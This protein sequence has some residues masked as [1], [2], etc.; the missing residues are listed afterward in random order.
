MNKKE[1]YE[2]VVAEVEA[3]TNLIGV[4]DIEPSY[5]GMVEADGITLRV[6]AEDGVSLKTPTSVFAD[7]D[8]RDGIMG[9]ALDDERF[10]FIL[11][12]KI[13]KA[14]ESK[15]ESNS[16]IEQSDVEALATAGMVLTLWE[17]VGNA[18]N[19]V[20][21]V[22]SLVKQF[23]LETPVLTGMAQFM[24]S[25]SDFPVGMARQQLVSALPQ[26][27]DRINK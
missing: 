2:S 3:D 15:F 10:A 11:S 26:V 6:K 25:N 18:M 19:N 24:L 17:Q 13:T 7:P 22:E 21:T 12:I 16:P 4:V 9:R 27:L 14:I 1:Q 20:L 23:G 8:V 5:E